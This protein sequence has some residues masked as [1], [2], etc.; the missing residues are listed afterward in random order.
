[1]PTFLGIVTSNAGSLA[2]KFFHVR[3]EPTIRASTPRDIF[4]EDLPELLETPNS[5][6][7]ISDPPEPSDAPGLESET[8][9]TSEADPTTGNGAVAPEGAKN[10][11]PPF[12][13]GP[14]FQRPPQQLYIDQQYV[15][16]TI[17]IPVDFSDRENLAALLT[18]APAIASS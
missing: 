6:E 18:S 7:S 16:V 10:S 9:E 4:W 14:V 12:R 13:A 17:L 11:E 5:D 2:V 15:P 1:M 3:A 8:W